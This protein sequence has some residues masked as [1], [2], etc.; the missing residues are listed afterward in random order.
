MRLVELTSAELAAG[1]P[2]V[3]LL[4][5]GSI[6]QHGGHIDARNRTDRSGLRVLISLPPG[7]D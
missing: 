6:E 7:D 1:P 3:L 2:R 5:L 4:P